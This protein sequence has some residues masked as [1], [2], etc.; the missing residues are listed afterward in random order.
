MESCIGLLVYDLLLLFPPLLLTLL[1][2]GGELSVAMGAVIFVV[3][4]FDGVIELLVVFDD[5]D[6]D[7]P[8]MAELL[9]LFVKG[10]S[11]SLIPFK[12]VGYI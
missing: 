8:D 3:F 4:L 2:N 12:T 1:D 10:N 5:E 7:E 6:E 9:L 11:S